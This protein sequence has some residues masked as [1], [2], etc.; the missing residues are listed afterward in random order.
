MLLPEI[1]IVQMYYVND[2]DYNSVYNVHRELRP[3]LFKRLR[4]FVWTSPI[5]ETVRLTPVVYDSDIEILHR[6]VSDHSRRDFSTYIKAF[7][8]GTQ[9]EDYVITML[10]KELYISGSDKDFMD[11]K[12]IFA[13]ILINENRSDDIRQEV[14]CVLVKIYRIAGDMGE[15]FKLAL[16]CVADNPS[17]EIC[18][19]LG[20]YYYDINDYAE[21]AMWYYNAIYETSSVLDITS[22]GNKPLY[23]LSRCYDK[24]S[25]TSEDIEQIAQFRQMA[26]DYKYQAEQW[27]LPDEI[28]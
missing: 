2:N 18:Y 24:L 25:E 28:V 10:C 23:A 7:A 13:D 6:P 3:K 19:E 9:L 8:R 21:A 26:E 17:S 4:P 11:F 15:F 14:N 1:D 16:R 12:D 27:K 5:H 20:N 22:G